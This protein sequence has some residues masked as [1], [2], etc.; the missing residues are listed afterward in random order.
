MF[1]RPV[2]VLDFETTGLGAKDR[3]IEIAA[4]RVEAARETVFHRLCDP[5]FPLPWRITE[6]TGLTDSDLTGQPAPHLA[7]QEL[8]EVLLYDGPLFVAHNA[9][10]DLRF[11]HQEYRHAGLP[12]FAGPVLCTRNLARGLYPELGS[13]K[14]AD[15][16]NHLGITHERAHRALDDVH[17][18]HAA[19]QQMV[20]EAASQ[21]IDPLLYGGLGGAR[22]DGSLRGT[23]TAAAPR[24]PRPP[25]P[26]DAPIPRA[27]QRFLQMVER[28]GKR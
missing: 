6:I 5:G 7:I 28:K 10:F 15:V 11:L 4:I 18:T 3:V 26:D 8:H 25:Q 21:Q 13:Y 27:L 2:V 24:A 12:L 9:S 17:A 14:L 20:A 22:F 16:V 19:L 1:D 23:A